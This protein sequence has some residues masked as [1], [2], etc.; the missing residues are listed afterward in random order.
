MHHHHHFWWRFFPHKELTRIYTSVAIRSFAI[1]MISLFLP[2]YLYYEMDYSLTSTLLFFIYYSL[3]FAI[4]TPFAAKFSAKFGMKHAILLSIPLYLLG[5]MLLYFLPLYSIPLFII[6]SL[7][8]ASISFYWMGLHLIFHRASDHKHRGEEFGKRA[9]ISIFSTLFGPLFGGLLI[10]MVGF[11]LVFLI[12][13]LFLFLSAF[14]LFLSEDKHL[15]YHF[16]FKS[17][18]NKKHWKHSVFFISRGSWNIANGVIWPLFVFFILEDYFS[19]GLI[20]SVL[21]G[22]SAILL[23]L[24]GKMSDKVGKRKIAHYSAWFESLSWFIRSFA[25]TFGQIFGATVFAGITYGVMES[26]LGAMEYDKAKGDITSYFVSRE[27]FICL[28]RMLLLTFVILTDSLSGGL[29]F[30]GVANFA[31]LLF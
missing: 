3:A 7:I 15:K 17:I 31:V 19:L 18:L 4:I 10:K 13:S 16:S 30:N 28:G 9:S 12:A 29:I 5:I 26:P 11:K 21:A 6:G 20:G 25:S 1:S 2:L 23:L 14:F 8:G 24:V 27:I 22:V